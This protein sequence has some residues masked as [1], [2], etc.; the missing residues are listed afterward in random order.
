MR[1]GSSTW[2]AVAMLVAVLAL[3]G[4]GAQTPASAPAEAAPV[5]AVAEAAAT[6]LPEA[7]AA[8]VESEAQADTAAQADAA[9][10]EVRT[11]VIDPA[12]SQARFLIDEVL[13]GSPKT[14]VG[15]TEQVSGEVRVNLGDVL[16]TEVGPIQIDA[17]DLET[18][19]NFRNRAIR[20]QILDSGNDA[21][22]YITFAPT[23]LEGLPSTAAVGEPFEFAIT[24]D[25]QIRDISAPV[26]F[27]V[28][29][30]PVSEGELHGEARATVQR[31]SFDLRIPNVPRVTNVSED[32]FLEFDFVAVAQ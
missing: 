30:T 24:G 32:V 29:V 23:A 3:A 2:V 25:L 7:E 19:D 8:E 27:N 15:I 10:G 21:Y 20:S 26:T 9:A 1:R 5:E 18:D 4:C 22:Q 31:A 16:L 11:F 17:R 14:V 28:K 6:A 13:M 12:R